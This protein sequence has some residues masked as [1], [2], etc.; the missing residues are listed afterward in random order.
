MPSFAMDASLQQSEPRLAGLL[1]L[2]NE[3]LIEIAS[4]VDHG[5]IPALRLVCS[6]LDPIASPFLIHTI[7]VRQ[8][9]ESLDYVQRIL[10]KPLIASG[11][12]AIT[13]NLGHRFKSLALD[14]SRFTQVLEDSMLGIYC[15][16]QTRHLSESNWR[17]KSRTLWDR[18]DVCMFDSDRWREWP[19]MRAD[20]AKPNDAEEKYEQLIQSAYE[21]Y[22][23]E[24]HETSRIASE[25]SLV[26]ALVKLV[27]FAKRPLVLKFANVD[28]WYEHMA[29]PGPETMALNYMANTPCLFSIPTRDRK[30][31]KDDMA[32]LDGIIWDLPIALHQAGCII[33]TFILKN[34]LNIMGDE[35]I[36]ADALSP[37]NNKLNQLR[38][39]LQNL[40]QFGITHLRHMNMPRNAYPDPNHAIKPPA[41]RLKFGDLLRTCLSG[42][43]LRSVRLRGDASSDWATWADPPYKRANGKRLTPVPT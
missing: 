15:L 18:R 6:R 30:S 14:K 8:T 35:V 42:P 4:L 24:H 31:V 9:Q 16:G 39:A 1:Y 29:A 12:R 13:V 41:K 3:L 22:K 11:V 28:G 10:E 27:S 7:S 37:S 40:T 32:L 25:G 23:K 36:F 33:H 38:Q 43:G 20:E 34:V 19:H 5:D 21:R 17:F 2:P 26:V